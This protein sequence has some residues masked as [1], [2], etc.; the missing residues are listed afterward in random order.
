MLAAIVHQH[1]GAGMNIKQKLTWAFAVIA[2][3][4]IVVVASIVIVNLRSDAADDFVDSS[5]REI[6]QVANAMQLFFEGIS[7]N[8]DYL[9]GH[10]LINNAGDGIKSYM[11]VDA[12]SIPESDVHKE[13]FDFFAGIAKSHPAYSYVSYG[14]ANGSYAFWPG[15]PKMASYDPRLLLVWR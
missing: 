13:M 7:Q 14:L 6:R 11:T 10:P 9:A 3:L 5:G 4:P 12:P 8:V 15:D 1:P 2:C